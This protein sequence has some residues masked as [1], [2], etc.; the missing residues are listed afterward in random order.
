[1]NQTLLSQFSTDLPGLLA[2]QIHMKVVSKDTSY[3]FIKLLFCKVDRGAQFSFQLLLWSSASCYSICILCMLRKHSHANE[4][5]HAIFKVFFLLETC[6]MKRCLLTWKFSADNEAHQI[7]TYVWSLCSDIAT[8][9][10]VLR[11]VQHLCVIFWAYVRF[12]GCVKCRYT[13]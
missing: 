13:C 10:N 1:M 3:D 6:E 11:K 12:E 9:L 7:C 2:W 8:V 5:D 4:F